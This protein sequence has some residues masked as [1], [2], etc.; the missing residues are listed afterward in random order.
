[1]SSNDYGPNGRAYDW[2]LLHH[3][4]PD[5]RKKYVENVHRLLNQGGKYLSVC[6]NEK[7]PGFGGAGKYRK[8]RLG[9]VLYFSSLE[10]LKGLFERYFSIEEAKVMTI[11]GRGVEHMVNYVFMERK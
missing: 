11:Q 9:T 5:E 6:F 7:D 2:E 4:F 10:E 3:I 1:M 8:T